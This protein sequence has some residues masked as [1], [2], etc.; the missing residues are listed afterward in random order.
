MAEVFLGLDFSPRYF[1][2]I[3][4]VY[5][6]QPGVIDR[7]KRDFGVGEGS[8]RIGSPDRR[9]KIIDTARMSLKKRGINLNNWPRIALPVRPTQVINGHANEADHDPQQPLYP[10]Q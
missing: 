10:L 1:R 8:R 2:V 3:F 9:L 6:R 5:P 7:P 4:C